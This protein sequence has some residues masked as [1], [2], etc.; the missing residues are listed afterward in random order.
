MAAVA[1]GA[2]A[3]AAALNLWGLVKLEKLAYAAV[4]VP[5]FV[6]GLVDTGGRAAERFGVVDERWRVDDNEKQKIEEVINEV[7]NAPLKGERPF[8][9][10]TRLENLPKPLVELRKALKD[11]K[12]EVEKDAA[13]VAALVHY[14][15]LIN[16]AGVYREWAELYRWAGGLVEKQEFTVTADK[17]RELRE[18]H[19]RLEGVAGRVLEELN[20]VLVLHSQSDF[21]KERPDLLNKLKSLL[22]V[23]VEKAE[24]LAEA[25]RVEL[26]KYSN[27]G[28]G[29]KVYAALLSV[30]KDGIYGH[31]TMLLMGEGALADVVLLTPRS[32]Y[33]KADDIAGARGEAVD[34]SRSRRRAKAGEVAGGRGGAVDPSRVG[35]AG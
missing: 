30:A 18:A 26:S 15:T 25:R 8:S 2:V 31:A 9:K 17:I 24:E 6:A 16:N 19:N 28:M 32:A 13:V 7:L 12:D 3:L 10:L 22:E 29:T 11:V 23:D 35:A 4:G 1:A 14:K 20:R 21:Y 5:P 33:E 34:P 27:A